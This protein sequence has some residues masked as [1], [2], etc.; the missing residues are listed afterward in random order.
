MSKDTYNHAPWVIRVG[1][2]SSG[3]MERLLLTLSAILAG[4]CKEIWSRDRSSSCSWS[5]EGVCI[6]QQA[7]EETGRYEQKNDWSENA[8]CCKVGGQPEISHG[9]F[10]FADVSTRPVWCRTRDRHGSWTSKGKRSCTQ[11]YRRPAAATQTFQSCHRPCRVFWIILN[12]LVFPDNLFPTSWIITIYHGWFWE[13]AS[14]RRRTLQI[15][16]FDRK[17]RMPIERNHPWTA[18]NDQIAI[19]YNDW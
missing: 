1:V 5:R 9:R 3:E 19:L 14:P 6:F 15:S 18:Q 13:C 17:Q 12:D 10:G 16:T 7:K 8:G 4:G 11:P 2:D